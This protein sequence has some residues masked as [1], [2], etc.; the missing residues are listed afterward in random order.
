MLEAKFSSQFFTEILFR[1]R[2]LSMLDGRSQPQ[3]SVYSF[4]LIKAEKRNALPGSST[5]SMP[6]GMWFDTGGG[7][8]HAKINDQILG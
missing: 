2:R 4:G 5:A 7:E 6:Y 3:I 8:L 1:D